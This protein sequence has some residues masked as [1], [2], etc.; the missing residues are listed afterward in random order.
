MISFLICLVFKFLSN[1]VKLFICALH[2]TLMILYKAG[3]YYTNLVDV[4]TPFALFTLVLPAIGTISTSAN[5]KGLNRNKIINKLDYLNIPYQFLSFL[6][7][8]IDGDGHIKVSGSKAGYITININIQLHLNDLSTLEYVQSILKLGRIRI[9][10]DQITPNAIFILNKTE[11]QDIFFPL[12][13]HHNLYFLTS[14]RR[15]QFN[16]AMYIFKNNIKKF[17]QI[18]NIEIPS[19]GKFPNQPLDYLKL[20]Y[21]K[22]WV[23]GFTNAEG[24]FLVKVNNDASAFALQL[25]QII[26]TELF[27]SFKLLFETDRKIS[28]EK[29]KY[30]QF[31]VS[32]KKDIQTVINFFSFSGLHSL[33]GHKNIQY[34]NWVNKLKISE[35]YKNLKFPE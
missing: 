2:G 27:E 29:N 28:T 10:K 15:D 7:G 21:F 16:R 17:D 32:S 11:L 35:R 6:V 4:D 5:K 9:Y 22:N 34:L 19:F 8:L 25:K 13:L 26:H 23:V 24:S 30:L 3:N 20:P 31:S 1:E 18:P 33:L 12:L 14:N